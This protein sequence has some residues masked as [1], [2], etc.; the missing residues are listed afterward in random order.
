MVSAVSDTPGSPAIIE[1]ATW[2]DLNSL[3]HLEQVCFP[4][5][6]W[7]LWDLIGVLTFSKVVRLKAMSDGRLVGFI[8]A[9]IRRAE[10]LAWIATIGVLPEYRQHGIGTTL[11]RACENRLVVPRIRLSVRASN[12]PAI[13]MYTRLGYKRSGVWSRYYSDGEDALVLEKYL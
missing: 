5:D 10:G 7:P 3:R 9:D 4:H 2:R 13:R 11:L 6:A 1:P 8:A 12:G